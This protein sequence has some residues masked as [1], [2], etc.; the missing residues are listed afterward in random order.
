MRKSKT[1]ANAL[2][3]HTT[4]SNTIRRPGSAHERHSRLD[5]RPGW[6]RNQVYG[7]GELRALQCA[8]VVMCPAPPRGMT[9]R[10]SHSWVPTLMTGG[11]W[12][13]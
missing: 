10:M 5:D 9:T 13:V 12:W 11:A 8:P 1:P 6:I 4:S 3:Y 2:K 7:P